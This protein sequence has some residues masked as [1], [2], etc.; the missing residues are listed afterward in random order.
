MKIIDNEQKEKRE[1]QFLKVEDKSRVILTSK[2]VKIET[3]YPNDGV[4]TILWSQSLAN[5]GYQKRSEFMYWGSVNGQEGIIRV[6]ASMFFAMN[7]AERVT[8]TS[9]RETEWIVSKTGEGK[10]TR[11][12]IVPSKKEIKVDEA[13]IAANTE[14]LMRLL[15]GYEKKLEEKLNGFLADLSL[16]EK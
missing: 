3:C 4:K 6:P 5:K 9:K 12:A 13:I 10:M 8:E 15:T 11:Y 16:T 1:G 7:E 2:L 14:K